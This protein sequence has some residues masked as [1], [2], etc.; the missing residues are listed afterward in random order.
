MAD[1]KPDFWI[2]PF[3]SWRESVLGKP[4]MHTITGCNHDFVHNHCH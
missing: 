2:A 3:A 4:D 1:N